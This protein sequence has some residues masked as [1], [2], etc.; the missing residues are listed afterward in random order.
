V[1]NDARRAFQ[2]CNDAARLHRRG[3]SF[4]TPWTEG[5]VHA[6]GGMRHTEPEF[7]ENMSGWL[8]ERSI[9]VSACRHRVKT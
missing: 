5:K 1:A 3:R 7:Q 2:S 6:T 8:S 4:D 9:D